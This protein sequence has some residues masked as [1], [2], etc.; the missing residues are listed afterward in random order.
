MQVYVTFFNVGT[1]S[2]ALIIDY[3]KTVTDEIVLWQSKE[4]YLAERVEAEPLEVIDGGVYSYYLAVAAWGAP[5]TL[6]ANRIVSYRA[7]RE[8]ISLLR[9]LDT[10]VKTMRVSAWPERSEPDYLSPPV[11]Q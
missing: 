7:P 4:Q 3:F 5:D 9:V 11:A 10:V 1:D 6:F 2:E 8:L